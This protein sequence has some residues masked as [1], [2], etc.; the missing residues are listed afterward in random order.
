MQ[1]TLQELL[2]S[3]EVVIPQIQR[4][5]AQG[6]DTETDL[7]K[8]FIGKIKLSLESENLPLNLDFVYGYTE[9]RSNDTTAFIPL[10][11]QQRLTTL[12]LLHWH[13]APRE[14]E[15]VNSEEVYFVS[16]EVQKYLIAFTYQTRIST[17]RFCNSLITD[18]LPNS[19]DAQISLIIKDAAWFMASWNYDPTIVSMLNMLDTIQKERFETNASWH[20]LIYGRKITFDYIDIKS[21]EFKLTDELYI[22]MNSRGKPLTPF[23]NFKA[24]FSSV[25]SSKDSDYLNETLIYQDSDVTFQQYFAFKIDSVWMDLFWNYRTKVTTTTDD[26]FLNFIYYIADFLYFR[27]KTSA[28]SSDVNHNIDFLRKTFSIKQNVLFLF[29]SFDFL[30]GLKNIESFFNELFDDLSTFDNFSNDLFLRSISG[31]GFDVKDKTILYAILTYC[32][33]TNTNIADNELKNFIRIVRNLLLA[34]RQ[35]NQSKRIEYT[36][37]LRLTNASEY[38][39]FIDGFITLLSDKSQK[40][41]YDIF[42]KNDFSGFTKDNIS[43]EKGKASLIVANSE[44]YQSFCLLEEH[45]YIQGNTANFK[46]DTND[47]AKKITAFLEIW[48]KGVENSLI[49]RAFLTVDDY[50]V[51]THNYSSLGRICYFGSADTWNRILTAADKEERESVSDNLN[52]FLMSYIATK[53]NNTTER[54][55]SLI[56]NFNPDIKDWRYYFVKYKAITDNRFLK[57]NLFSWGD[58]EGFDINSLGNSGSHPLHSYH[59]NPY[60]IVLGHLLN[61]NTKT[62][63]YYGRFTEISYLRVSNILDIKC[64]QKGWKITTIND[65]IIND[66][67]ITKYSLKPHKDSLI[68]LSTD[69]IDRIEIAIE[70]IKEIMENGA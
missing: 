6:R 3:H 50:S 7:R 55:Q 14:I 5:Y 24:Q 26:C 22:K 44:L 69:K 53:G 2:N 63:L 8:N 43:S 59:L 28:T 41:V 38:C 40:N 58:N 33:N 9:K 61:N 42:A 64:I 19:E 47:I 16:E 4:D 57:L 15:I 46:L 18:S 39:K 11:G 54:L 12:W 56:N 67:I 31:T 60:L 65:Y 35:T 17:K 36:T 49:I 27:N 20:N 37:N 1:F 45:K 13:L 32:I 62:Q 52:A 21:D 29:N 25:L 10:D 30:A 48:A 51:M 68:L 34:V 66:N 70:L 23:E